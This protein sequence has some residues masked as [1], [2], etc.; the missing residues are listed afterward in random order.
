MPLFA[1]AGTVTRSA[2]PSTSHAVAGTP[3]KRT[4]IASATAVPPIRTTV[5]AVP[6]AG[7]GAVGAGGASHGSGWVLMTVVGPAVTP[8][9]DFVYVRL[10]VVGLQHAAPIRTSALRSV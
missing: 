7:T 2:P 9:G 10:T 1:P 6:E 4:A 8:D 5:P 3:P